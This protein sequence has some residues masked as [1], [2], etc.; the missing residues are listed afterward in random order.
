MLAIWLFSAFDE[1]GR[2]LRFLD[3][4]Q[5]L[6]RASGCIPLDLRQM[7]QKCHS[8][9]FSWIE[10]QLPMLIMSFILTETTWLPKKKHSRDLR[11]SWGRNNFSYTVSVLCGYWCYLQIWY[12]WSY[13]YMHSGKLE[14]RKR[15]TNGGMGISSGGAGVTPAESSGGSGE[16]HDASSL[17]RRRGSMDEA[18]RK[19]YYDSYWNRSYSSNQRAWSTEEEQR[20]GLQAGYGICAVLASI[21]IL[22]EC[23]SIPTLNYI[24]CWLTRIELVS[25]CSLCRGLGFRS[26][27][28]TKKVRCVSLTH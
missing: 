14:K 9:S 16:F 24:M 4:F 12:L 27:Y 22:R 15:R 10:V 13:R 20:S 1:S 11:E 6:T 26:S 8:R 28:F 17:P 19:T 23:L 21:A 2:S 7:S 18:R 25:G 3:H 5:A